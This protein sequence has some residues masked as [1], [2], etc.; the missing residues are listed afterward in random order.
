MRLASGDGIL[1]SFRFW[2]D[3]RY[4]RRIATTTAV[5]YYSQA[6][7]WV[8]WC[9]ENDIDFHTASQD[10]M[11]IYLGLLQ[12]TLTPHTVRH[13]LIAMRIFYDYAIY[14][15]YTTENPAR[16]LPAPKAQ[17]RPSPAFTE[18]EVREMFAAC[19]DYRERAVY[20]L[21]LGG[22][23]RRAEVFGVKR[24]DCNFEAG[25]VTVLGKGSQYRIVAP[26]ALAMH[27]LALAL[28]FDDRLIPYKFDIYIEN[29]V[30]RLAKK[31]GVKG[32]VHPHRFRSH[33]AVSYLKMGG[34]VNDLMHI[35]GHSHVQMSM[36]YARDG[37]KQRAIE[38]QARI[39]VAA[40]MLG[41][42]EPAQLMSVHSA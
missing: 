24:S 5:N 36:L 8:T 39:D 9:Q 10:D 41:M 6:K 27:E 4:P 12:R 42:L 26:G 31:A 16:A 37:E 21:L 40:R 13:R 23:L 28:E 20:L 3:T 15:G 30:K 7:Q 25:T 29:L 1:D 34:N 17:S 33:F 35:L 22:G 2:L 38:S 11:A 32:R 14:R 19:K 18:R